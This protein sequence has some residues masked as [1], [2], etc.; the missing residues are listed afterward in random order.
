MRR[1]L[2]VLILIAVLLSLAACKPGTTPGPNPPASLAAP[3]A[4]GAPVL[5]SDLAKL[6]SF[7]APAQAQGEAILLYGRVLDTTGAPLPGAVVEIWQTDA[8]G[9]YD[10]PGDPNTASRDQAFQ[11]YGAATA[12]ESGYY[13]FRTLLPGEYE[14]RPRHI[15]VKVRL[16]GQVVLTTQFYFEQDL[17]KLANE[18]IYR[19]AGN[20]GEQ[21]ILHSEQ[22]QDARGQTVRTEYNDLVLDG[23]SSGILPATPAQTEGPYYPQVRVDEYD[24]DLLVK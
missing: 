10:H 11:F 14:P 9:V 24:N 3:S 18:G 6:L 21:L 7:D 15:H 19:Q 22:V 20:R 4:P 1:F 8:N 16:D 12:N 2:L 13:V 23:G 17:E 5:D